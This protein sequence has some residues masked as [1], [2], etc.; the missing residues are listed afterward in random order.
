[1]NEWGHLE[2]KNE[3]GREPSAKHDRIFKE[4]GG[5]SGREQVER[6]ADRIR[7]E[8]LLTLEELERRRERALDVRYHALRHRDLLVGAAAAALVLAGT[9]VGL[10]AWRRYHREHILAK[11]RR[12]ALRRA[13]AHPD[14]VASRA[15]QRP[16]AVELGRKLVLIFA[17]ALASAVAKNS[18]AVLVPRRQVTAP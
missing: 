2:Q 11:K 4:A 3:G 1:M 18:A 8:L 16:L 6:T 14:R 12:R 17:A 13:W 10:A 15:E 9:G 7:D 5:G